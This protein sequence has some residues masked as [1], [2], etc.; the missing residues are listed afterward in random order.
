M[1]AIA[2]APAYIIS[3]RRSALGR[4]G[5]LHRTRRLEDLTSPVI[6]AA[7][8]DGGLQ[9]D[10]VDEVIIGNT[11]FG[12]N[13][14]RLI[15][16]A[17]GLPETVPALTV[18]RQCTSGLDAI[19]QGIRSIAVGECDIVLAGGAESLSTAPWR[20]AKPR[21]LYQMP[22][23]IGQQPS[24]DSSDDHIHPYESSELLAQRHGISRAAQDAYTLKSYLKA[25]S[26]REAKRF[27]GEIVPIRANKDEARDESAIGPSLEDIENELS[28]AQPSGTLTPANTSHPHDGA[29]IVIIVSESV[30]RELGQPPALRMIACAAEGVPPTLEADA[31]IAAVRKLYRRMNGFDR[32]SISAVELGETSAAQALACM[33]ELEI[34][35]DLINGDGGAIVRGHPMGAAG[36][37]LVV[38]MFS[39]LLRIKSQ[40]SSHFGII[41]QGGLGGLGLAALFETT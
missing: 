3:A 40:D 11:T 21:N 10:R 24:F 32:S 1:S 30:W 28:Y 9:A 37:V 35:E 33:S 20:I 17:A 19:L 34:D 22:H 8:R 26:A 27:V 13:P 36:A 16:L 14:A 31:P 41:A 39:Q 29:A 6:E 38:R 18:D 4:I 23:F 2:A 25:E 5:G 15:S 12:G 7:L